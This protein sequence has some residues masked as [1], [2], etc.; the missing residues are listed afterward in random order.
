MAGSALTRTAAVLLFAATL[1]TTSTQRA[2]AE[3]V[4]D[5]SSRL[6]AITTAFAG[7]QVLLYGAVPKDSGEIAMIVRGPARDIT[8]RRKSRVGPL[9]INTQALEF[10]D[11]PSFYAVASSVPLNELAG[12]AAR[13]RHEL[14]A[15]ELRLTPL[16]ARAE[17]GG[18]RQLPRRPDPQP[19]TDRPV[20]HR[21]RAT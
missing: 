21:G 5:L 19:A 11:V 16:A 4:Y 14:G 17:R 20:L 1:V 10:R 6:I 9:W 8:V 7:T 18:D 3:F 15:E 12:P 2:D 13:S